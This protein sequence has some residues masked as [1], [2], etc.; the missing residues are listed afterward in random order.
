MMIT[1]GHLIVPQLRSILRVLKK[2]QNTVETSTFGAE[3][4]ALRIAVE[5]IEGL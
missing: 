3:F 2:K 1:Y 4:V 5:L